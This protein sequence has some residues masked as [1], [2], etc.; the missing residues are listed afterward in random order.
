MSKWNLDTVRG[1]YDAFARTEFPADTFDHDAEWHTDP[2]LPRPMAHYGRGEVGAYFERFIGAWQ[3]LNAEPVDMSPLPG[4]QVV[5]VVRMGPRIAGMEPTVAHLW[6]LD[7]GRVTRVQVFGDRAAALAA[8][9]APAA[10]RPAGPS[11]ADREWGRIREI[12]GPAP[13]P[14][15]T[16]VRDLGQVGTALDLGCGDGRLTAELR[17][18]ELTAADVSLVALKRA[19]RRLPEATIVLLEAGERLPFEPESFDLV[20]CADTVPEVQD[21]ALTVADAK[22]VLAPGGTLAITAPA[23]GRRTGVGVLTRGFGDQFDPR[24]PVLRFFTRRSLGELLDM[25]G[26][27]AIEIGRKDGQ[28][29]ATARR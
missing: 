8:A 14:L 5:A 10:P 16:F 20:L 4:E 15:A 29:L 3:A 23:H 1:V 9:A 26:F 28:L 13:E 24:R 2:A 21:V 6:T 22:R 27:D 25:A 7:Q 19:R 11:L 12:R 18:A 17:A